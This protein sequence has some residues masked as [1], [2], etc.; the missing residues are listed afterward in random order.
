M[1][2]TVTTEKGTLAFNQTVAMPSKVLQNLAASKASGRLT[3][4]DP[5]DESVQWRIYLGDGK[6][7]FASSAMGQKERLTY[8]LKRYF[9]SREFVIP[10]SFPGEYQYIC[11]IW[12]GGL[13]SLK[14][15]R[16]LLYRLT[17]EALIQFLALSRGS[18]QFEK[19]VGLDPILL[20]LPLK[21]VVVPLRPQIRQWIQ[22]R[23]EI[24]SPF[25]RPYINNL[26]TVV[27]YSWLGLEDDLFIDKLSSALNRNHCL[28]EVAYHT[29]KHIL[30]LALFF[31]PL[32]KNGGII[33]RPYQIPQEDIRP[34]V[35]CID[36]S[37]ATQRIVKMTLEASGFR[38]MNIIEPAHALTTFVRN[39]PDL[40]LMDINMPEIDG[41]ELCRMFGQSTLLRHIP[42]IM[43]TGRDGLLDRI[44]ARMVGA[45][46][47]LSKPF[48][49]Q[50][51]IELVNSYIP[52]GNRE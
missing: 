50:D 35:A 8:L 42:V 27:N 4:F 19:T 25:Q 43:L 37:A 20:S 7:H 14:Q 48:K 28:Y 10:N 12:Q 13:L 34:I 47:Y 3:I 30:E 18:L 39:K 41:Y 24:S 51:L 36:D 22:I 52:I 6:I 26:D 16:Q 5:N 2:L 33:M 46:N 29:D 11:K 9:P 23:P 44:R 15:A 49:P 45:V 32:I 21:D 17:Q 38:V 31:Q 40:I 1:N